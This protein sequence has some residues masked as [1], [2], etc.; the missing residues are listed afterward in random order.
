MHC[1]SRQIVKFGT[2]YE[3]SEIQAY[4]LHPYH[5]IFLY[6]KPYQSVSSSVP[7]ILFSLKSVTGAYVKMTL[8][9]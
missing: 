9:Y 8:L 7:R 2:L 6:N 4:I 1:L 5:L 3:D